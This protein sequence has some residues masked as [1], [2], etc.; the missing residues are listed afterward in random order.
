MLFLWPVITFQRAGTALGN[1]PSSWVMTC[2]CNLFSA[3]SRHWLPGCADPHAQLLCMFAPALGNSFEAPELHWYTWGPSTVGYLSISCLLAILNVASNDRRIPVPKLPGKLLGQAC[4]HLNN[5][6]LFTA[7][8][9]SVST[10]L[11]PQIDS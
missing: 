7:K 10:V 8:N 6:N 5:L 9:V 11:K 1:Y 2:R 3:L 4:F